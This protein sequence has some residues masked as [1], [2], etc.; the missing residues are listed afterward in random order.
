MLNRIVDVW[1]AS[2]VAPED[3]D[4]RLTIYASMP[5]PAEVDEHNHAVGQI[6][7][8]RELAE[9]L[10]EHLPGGVLDHMLAHLLRLTAGSLSVRHIRHE[11]ETHHNNN[12]EA[13][14]HV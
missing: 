9:A 13:G 1:H 14:P 4:A 7:Q 6:T 8:G 12:V 2:K 3:P 5:E 10:W 11:C